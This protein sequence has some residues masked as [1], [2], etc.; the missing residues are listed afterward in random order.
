MNTREPLSTTLGWMVSCILLGAMI[1]A[2]TCQ[3]ARPA[4]PPAAPTGNHAAEVRF[5]D[6]SLV[7]LS[8]QHDSI[9]V[10]TAYGKLT[11][12]LADVRRID[13]GLHVPRKDAER[14]ASLVRH[15]GSDQYKERETAS[16]EII[17][18]GHLALPALR[19]AAKSSDKEVAKRAAVALQRLQEQLPPELLGLPE[20]DTVHAA[21]FTITGRV[22]ADS[23]SAQSPHF[24]EQSLKLVD[25][26]SLCM[27]A[28]ENRELSVDASK[29]EWQDTGVHVQAG[30]RLVITAA[31]DVELWPQQPGQYLASPKGFNII[32]KGGRF[33][34]GALVGR[35]GNSGEFMVGEHWD[36]TAGVSGN[37]YL[38]IVAS[39]WNNAS[40][41]KFQVK[42]RAV[43]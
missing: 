18:F 20:P 42:V 24:G 1:I 30:T 43:R 17:D 22:A 29:E 28:S 7:R 12:P 23:L 33:L 40:T 13:F 41:G 4:E 19:R 2:L 38:R 10:E 39:P 25:V 21:A 26:R 5:H 8:L 14:I 34:A 6:G 35:I 16:R 36:T 37:L 9:D 31:G 3:R 27:T 32:G 11:V 15:L